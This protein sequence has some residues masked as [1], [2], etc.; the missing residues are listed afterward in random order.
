MLL[1][2]RGTLQGIRTVRLAMSYLKKTPIG[3]RLVVE[4]AR[5]VPVSVTKGNMKRPIRDMEDI[6]Q[7]RKRA[8]VGIPSMLFRC[9]ASDVCVVSVA[10]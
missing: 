8:G 10:I 6:T 3:P 7:E 2:S 4:S 9:V 5:R 1:M